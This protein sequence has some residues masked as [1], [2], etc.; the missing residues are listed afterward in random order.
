MS[1][2]LQSVRTVELSRAYDDDYALVDVNTEF[3]AGTATAVLGPNGAGK[4]TLISL[5]TTLARPTEGQIFFGEREV[6][7][8]D[9]AIRSQIGYVGHHTMLYGSLTAREN[10]LFF[11]RLYGLAN[12]DDVV[13]R[14]S[15]VVGVQ[16]DADRPVGEFSRGMSQRL[17]I[18]RAL[19]QNPQVLLLDEPFTGLDQKGIARAQ[20]LFSA[21]RENGAI[22]IIVSHD[23]GVTGEL[24]DKALVL[25]RGRVVYDGDVRESLSNTYRLALQGEL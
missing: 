20:S 18:A 10:L 17:S 13:S 11:G 7:V 15:E 1:S 16:R 8:D 14:D 23:L 12:L 5:L 4:S 25:R 9:S 6:G 21:R 22:L 3:K 2:Q 24:V 19:M